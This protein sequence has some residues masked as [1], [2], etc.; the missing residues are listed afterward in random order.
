MQTYN[1]YARNEDLNEK[2]YFTVEAENPKDAAKKAN[3]K[4]SSSFAGELKDWRVT[5]T[6]KA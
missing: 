5:L 1:V 4:I 3:Q 6:I 2:R